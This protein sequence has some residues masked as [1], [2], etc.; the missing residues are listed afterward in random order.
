[1]FLIVG[2]QNN[3]SVDI[4]IVIIRQHIFDCMYTEQQIGK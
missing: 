1:M 4:E 3:K 2:I